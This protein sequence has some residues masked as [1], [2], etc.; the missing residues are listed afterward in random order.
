MDEFLSAFLEN[1]AVELL[2][3]VVVFALA[4]LGKAFVQLWSEFKFNAPDA[5]NSLERAA[6]MAVRAAE[7]A[8]AANIID[9]K[10]AY[11]L[12]VAEKWLALRGLRI[13]LDLI[14]AAI[15][16]AVKTEFNQDKEPRT[17]T[18]FVDG[19]LNGRL[20]RSLG[21]GN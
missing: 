4:Y 6:E 14:A 17:L 11:A 19:E 5:A 16:A 7:Q 8:G 20:D 12:E 10:K 2:P 3:V 9:D 1:L 13:D 15:E 18:G 21:A